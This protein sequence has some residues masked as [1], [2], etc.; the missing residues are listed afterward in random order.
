MQPLNAEEHAVLQQLL[1]RARLSMPAELEGEAAN[2]VFSTDS[3]WNLAPGVS[4]T[5]ASKRRCDGS[6]ER[7]LRPAGTERMMGYQAMGVTSTPGPEASTGNFGHTKRGVAIVLPA[8][9]HSLAMWGRSIVEF[10]KYS[11][12]G[13]TYSE[14]AESEDKDM[15]SYIKWCK[16]QVDCSEGFLKDFAFYLLAREYSPDQRPVIPGTSHVRKLR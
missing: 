16:S 2:S 9:I 13:W 14:M 15:M 3:D 11:S 1:A 6:P 10:G 7:G 12:R 4:M 5:D 8:G